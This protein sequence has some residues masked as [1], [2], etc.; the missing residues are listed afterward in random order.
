MIFTLKTGNKKGRGRPKY[1]ITDKY[2]ACCYNVMARLATTE[3]E[4][5]AQNGGQQVSTPILLHATIA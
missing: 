4:A 1:V 5:C 2:S 3:L